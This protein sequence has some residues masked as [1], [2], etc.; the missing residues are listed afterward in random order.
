M[1]TNTG[2]LRWN[3]KT[4]KIALDSSEKIYKMVIHNIFWFRTESKTNPR[5]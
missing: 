4:L 5:G 2:T 1:G 3:K